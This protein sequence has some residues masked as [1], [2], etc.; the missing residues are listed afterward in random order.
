MHT[1]CSMN[2]VFS[3][4][5]IHVV[6]SINKSLVTVMYLF[7]TCNIWMLCEDIFMDSTIS[8]WAVVYFTD[9][10]EK[11]R[12]AGADITMSDD[13]AMETGDDNLTKVEARPEEERL[14]AGDTIVSLGIAESLGG[15]G[16]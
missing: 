9:G 12:D 3:V 6:H 11:G 16:N 8:V 5:M 2:K 1:G 10:D 13:V 14:D 7:M 15:G 4:T